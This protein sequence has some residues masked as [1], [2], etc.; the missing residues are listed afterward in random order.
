MIRLLLRAT[1]VALFG[2]CAATMLM[3]LSYSRHAALSLDMDREP[4]P[5]LVRGLYPPE[6]AGDYTFAWTSRQAV[7]TLPGLSRATPWTCT[8]RIRGARGAGVPQPDV[9]A[10]VDGLIA[11]TVTA[12]NDQQDLDVPV[13]A[14]PSS[15]GVTLG[16]TVSRTVVPGPSDTRELGVQVD[17][18]TC[19]PEVGAFVLPPRTALQDAAIAGALFGLALALCGITLGSAI[20]GVVLVGAGQ[21]LALSAGPAPYTGF[22]HAAILLGGWISLAIV[23]LTVAIERVISRPLRNTARFA[24]LF[25]GVSLYLQLLGLLHPSKLVIDAVFHAH[26]LEWVLGGRYFFTQPMPGGVSFPY[27]IGLYVFA[28]PWSL[29]TSDHVTLLRVVVTA[30]QVI[31]GGLLYPLLARV[32]NDRVVAAIAVALFSLVPLPYELLGNANLANVFA[33]A[34]A[35]VAVL[36]AAGWSFE[37]RRV[38]HVGGLFAVTALAFLSHVSTFAQLGV[39]LLAVAGLYWW[40]GNRPLRVAA[41]WIAIVAVVAGVVAVVLYYS[42]FTD[43]YLKALRVGEVSTAEMGPIQGGAA[44]RRGWPAVHGACRGR[45]EAHGFGH[46][47]AR[48]DPGGDGRLDAV[49]ARARDRVT[50]AVLA[51]AAAYLLFLGVGLMRVDAPFQRYAAEFVGRVVLATYPAAVILAARGAGWGWRGGIALRA[52]V[53]VLLLWAVSGGVR[54]WEGW[55][56]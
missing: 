32:W 25:S 7:M 26:R 50:L 51:W 34:V 44:R 16:L 21:S 28:A 27:A 36:A 17:R 19:R 42:H 35:L 45:A 6:R 46:R 14:R 5:G 56:R 23:V 54:S 41:R 2:A 55:L 18:F 8:W 29:L 31:A 37:R 15:A 33:Q 30:S 49:G 39:T 38:W 53:G 24:I 22:G 11:G 40:E 12:T 48:A 9:Q 43:V 3:V 20:L 4:P 13:P 47:M 1:A 10:S 52:A